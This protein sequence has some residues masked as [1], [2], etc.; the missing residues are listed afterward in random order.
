MQLKKWEGKK[1]ACTSQLIPCLMR[2]QLDAATS[3]LYILHLK[4]R[5]LVHKSNQGK[6]K[7]GERI[8]TAKPYRGK[9]K[10]IKRI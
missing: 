9:T 8:N 7:V 6:F 5:I 4:F 10:R 1:I 3:I 2:K